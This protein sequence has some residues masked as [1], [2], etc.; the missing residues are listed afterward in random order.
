MAGTACRRGIDRRRPD[1]WGDDGTVGRGRSEPARVR[2]SC[3]DRRTPG[4]ISDNGCNRMRSTGGCFEKRR[5]VRVRML[6]PFFEHRA[7]AILTFEPRVGG[8][9]KPVHVNKPGGIVPDRA[10]GFSQCKTGKHDKAPGRRRSSKSP[11]NCSRCGVTDNLWRSK[12]IS[13]NW[14]LVHR[15]SGSTSPEK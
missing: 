9:R 10:G 14:V 7:M 12:F 8:S 1:G 11:G 5:I 6:A 4:G 15:P 13:G 2:R 3:S